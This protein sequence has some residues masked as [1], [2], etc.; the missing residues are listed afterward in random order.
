MVIIIDCS[1]DYDMVRPDLQQNLF[2]QKDN[3]QVFSDFNDLP[4]QIQHAIDNSRGCS[5]GE[6]RQF[7]KG[8]EYQ[9]FPLLRITGPFQGFLPKS[10]D[11]GR[12]PRILVQFQGFWSHSRD[13]G[14]NPKFP[15]TF[16]YGPRPGRW[17]KNEVG[18]SS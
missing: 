3:M 5:S 16:S 6:N 2:L 8:V 1:F 7:I 10:I 9:G 14:T 11:F 17:K 18:S 13:F 15:C 4:F 12:I